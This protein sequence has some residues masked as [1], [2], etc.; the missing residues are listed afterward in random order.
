M[1]ALSGEGLMAQPSELSFLITRQ[2]ARYHPPIQ[3]GT[4]HDG[5][6]S[7]AEPE[8]S[9]SPWR[10]LNPKFTFIDLSAGIGGF[11]IGFA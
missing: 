7:T 1:I 6:A 8:S 10:S 2:G 4:H 9:K 5:A 3:N 11:R